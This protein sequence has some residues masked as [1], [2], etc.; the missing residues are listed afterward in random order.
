MRSAMHA[1]SQLPE[2]G[3]TDVDRVPTPYQ[4]SYDD[5]DITGIHRSVENS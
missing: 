1:P 4:M 2:R 5:D 3:P